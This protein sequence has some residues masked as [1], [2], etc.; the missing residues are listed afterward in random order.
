MGAIQYIEDADVRNKRVLLRADFD[1]ARN[2][3][4]TISDDARIQS[5]LSTIHTLLRGNNKIIC[6]SKLGR[7][8]GRDTKYSLKVIVDRLQE[9]L[10]NNK[11][12][13]VDDFL[14]N[15]TLLKA[16]TP[17]QILVLENIRFYPEEKANDPQFAQKLAALGDVYVNNAFAMCHRS[18]ASIVGIPALLP[19]YAGPQLKKEIQG[20]SHVIENPQKPFVAIMGGAKISTKINL[21]GRLNELA[22]YLLIGGGLANILLKAHGAQIG[23]SF[24]EEDSLNEAQHL[25]DVTFQ[26]NTKLVL[27]VDA[28]V[29]SSKTSEQSTVKAIKDITPEDAIFDLGPQTQAM[30]GSI[31]AKA[32]TIIWNGPLGYIENPEFKRGT[33]F[34]YYSITQNTDAVSVVG[35]GDTLAAISK[36]EYLDKITHISM[37]GGAMLEFIEKGALPGIE[38]LKQ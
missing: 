26:K 10:P 23:T 18:E 19:A 2:E 36:K 35:G 3:D 20:I 25:M 22:D 33:D 34:V 9:Y 8:K 29:S 4:L 1:V 38:A 13:L 24:I 17:D 27:P 12:L 31:I 28:V 15:D 6:I 11:V 14:T 30:Y 32:K 16:Q 7:P 21:V 37:G 5:N